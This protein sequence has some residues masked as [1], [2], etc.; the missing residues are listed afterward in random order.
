MLDLDKFDDFNNLGKF[1]HV[2]AVIVDNSAIA[3]LPDSSGKGLLLWGIGLFRRSNPFLAH[4]PLNGVE[5]K[6]SI[7]YYG[8]RTASGKIVWS[9]SAPFVI[10]GFSKRKGENS[11]IYYVMSTWYPYNTIMMRSE[12]TKPFA[13]TRIR[14]SGSPIL[15][16]SNFGINGNFELVSCFRTEGPKKRKRGITIWRR[17]ISSFL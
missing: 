2:S 11:L 4:I 14:Y 3:N 12:I 6:D 17:R 5:T 13:D 15:I 7:R 8:G 10:P 1:I 9:K 16:Q